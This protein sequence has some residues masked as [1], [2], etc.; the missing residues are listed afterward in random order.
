MHG[1]LTGEKGYANAKQIDVIKF[2]QVFAVPRKER[3]KFSCSNHAGISFVRSW[4][5]N[6]IPLEQ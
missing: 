1:D 6:S 3:K 2:M 5:S 4:L